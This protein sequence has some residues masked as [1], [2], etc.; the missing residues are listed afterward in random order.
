MA[1][2]Y[3]AAA[4]GILAGVGGLLNFTQEDP[5]DK[6]RQQLDQYRRSVLGRDAPQAGPAQS[7]GYSGFRN[8]QQDLVSRLEALSK[9]EGPS[10]AAEQLKQAT[11]RNMGNQASIAQSGRGNAALASM[12][13]ANNMQRIGQQ[14]ASDSATAR[15]AEQQMA[16]GQLGTAV[17]Q[18]RQ[19]DE[20]NNQFNASEANKMA[21]ANLEAKLRSQGLNDQ[22]IMQIMQMQFGNKKDRIGDALMAGGTGL[23]AAGATSGGG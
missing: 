12:T 5:N 10:L 9:G 15:I 2:G 22:T 4:G 13:A 3:A 20:A 1:N 16:L 18:G 19:L 8:N 17:G 6:N 14:A 23:L 21:A 7:S 11:D